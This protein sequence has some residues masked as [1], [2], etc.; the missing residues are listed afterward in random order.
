MG[1]KLLWG[2]I[3]III[4]IFLP[5]LPLFQ[6]PRITHCMMIPGPG[7]N[8]VCLLINFVPTIILVLIGI[9]LI[10]RNK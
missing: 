9:F 7:F 1:K 10:I 5:F 6:Y 2:I 8:A 4:G 3:L